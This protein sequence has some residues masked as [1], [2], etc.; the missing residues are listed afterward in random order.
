MNNDLI[1]KKLKS[2][3]I[4]LDKQPNNSKIGIIIDTETTGLDYKICKIFEIALVVF[5]FDKD[6]YEILGILDKVN[7]LH[8]CSP[9]PEISKKISHVTDEDIKDKKFDRRKLSYWFHECNLVI[10]HNA[11]FDRK[12]LEMEFPELEEKPWVCSQTQIDYEKYNIRSTKLDYIAFKLGFWF[13]GHRA[14]NDCEALFEILNSK[15]EG[16]ECT[17]FQILRSTA[18][19]NSNIIYALNTPYS[20]KDLLREKDYWWNGDSEPRCWFKVVYNEEELYSHLNFLSNDIYKCDLDKI[21][22]KVYIKVLTAFDR[23]SIRE[24]KIKNANN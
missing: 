16:E 17:I 21:D 2:R 5:A 15:F 7:E 14:L 3:E 18:L 11:K 19:K 1:I 8:D 22:S 4:D 9:L 10:A 20:T 12:F 13:D 24:F 6:T 23:F